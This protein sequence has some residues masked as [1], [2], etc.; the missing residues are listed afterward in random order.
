MPT[1]NNAAKRK[2]S[3]EDDGMEFFR[4]ALTGN[5]ATG[6]ASSGAGGEMQGSLIQI[7]SKGG[8]LIRGT[9]YVPYALFD[10]ASITMME[11]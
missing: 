7:A 1:D 11:L 6:G 4:V 2:K 10:D 9:V 8:T 3:G 5:P